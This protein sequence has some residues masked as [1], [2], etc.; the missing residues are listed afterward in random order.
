MS[1]SEIAAALWSVVEAHPVNLSSDAERELRT[2]INESA[3]ELAKEPD[4]VEEGRAA[5]A[6]LLDRAAETKGARD[7]GGGGGDVFTID[8][9]ELEPA[10]VALALRDL[11]PLYPIC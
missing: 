9:V 8:E 1:E 11:C 3:S 2:L 10:D 5:V 4:R 6:Q 7:G